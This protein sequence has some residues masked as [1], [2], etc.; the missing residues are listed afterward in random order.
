MLATWNLPVPPLSDFTQSEEQKR[1]STADDASLYLSL[2]SAAYLAKHVPKEIAN[3]IIRMW[4]LCGCEEVTRTIKG[5]KVSPINEADTSNL[6]ASTSNEQGD[7]AS[8]DEPEGQPTAVSKSFDTPQSA[9]SVWDFLD[10]V[11]AKVVPTL[12][13]VLTVKSAPATTLLHLDKKLERIVMKYLIQ[14]SILCQAAAYICKYYFNA[15]IVS[16]SSS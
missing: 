16:F 2:R 11:F 15:V 5:A 8:G 7:G 10:F 6:S 13:L 14:V 3:C 12:G 1:E 4:T 9:H